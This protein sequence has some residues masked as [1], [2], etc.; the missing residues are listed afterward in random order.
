MAS[1][2]QFREWLRPYCNEIDDA[3]GSKLL[4]YFE[5][6][7]KWN[8]RMALTS[9]DDEQK[10]AQTLFGESLAACSFIGPEHGRLAD[11]GSGAGFPGL[12]LKVARPALE[13]FLIEPS[14]RKSVFLTEVSGAL[15]LESVSV[16]RGRIGVRDPEI[17]IS[18][19]NWVTSRALS[20]R[21]DILDFSATSLV[22]SGE[23]ML[24]VTCN[25]FKEIESDNNWIWSNPMPL[26]G[27]KERFIAVGQRRV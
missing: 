16:I 19:L 14:L 20:A 7:Q 10:I 1:L 21:R 23:V 27:T 17:G 4:T 3:T 24:W 12:V 25:V 6:L 2:A 8:R 18:Q 13:V 11:V 5:I 9:L 15:E 22:A 26:P